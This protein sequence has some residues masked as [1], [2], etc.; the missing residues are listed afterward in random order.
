L[1]NRAASVVT[2]TVKFKE[3]S[4]GCEGWYRSKEIC[5]Y[6][7]T[8]IQ[9]WNIFCSESYSQKYRKSCLQIYRRTETQI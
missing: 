4:K 7:F 5:I 8:E 6:R 2:N 1:S 3:I 9:N